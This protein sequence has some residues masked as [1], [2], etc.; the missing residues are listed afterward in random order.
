MKTKAT[1]LGIATEL[2]PVPIEKRRGGG[3]FVYRNRG[4]IHSRSFEGMKNP[5][6]FDLE[7]GFIR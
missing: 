6:F 7:L 3:K 4:R 1:V 2:D 5:A